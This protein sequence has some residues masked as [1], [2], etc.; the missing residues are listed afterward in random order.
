MKF[1]LTLFMSWLAFAVSAQSEIKPRNLEVA[2][3]KTTNL[4]FPA[5]IISIDRGSEHFAVQKSTANVLRVKAESVF[6]DTTNLTVIT[7]DGKLYSFLVSYNPSPLHL[8]IT[9]G[10]SL[11][12]K[13]DTSLITGCDHVLRAV[14]SLNGLQ[15]ESG[16]V[17]LALAGFYIR[18]QVLYCKLRVENRSQISYDIEQFRFYIR[19]SKQ[20][21][22]TSSQE[23]AIT[24][25]YISGET[26]AIAGKAAQILVVALPKFTIPDRK[27]FVVEIMERNG[28][29]NLII[30]ARNRHLIKAK[31]I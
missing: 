23:S 22:R 3:N 17:L 20:S 18:G 12:V 4:V 30:R 29:R 14:S 16:K 11:S 9:M 5:A 13:V 2:A 26:A 21:R 8:N 19:D 31:T 24:P 15:F 25:F 1:F 28:G 10:N 7:S 6:T 27:Y